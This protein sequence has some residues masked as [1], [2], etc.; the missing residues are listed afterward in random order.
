VSD[1]VLAVR[2]RALGDVVL[3]TPALRALAK[4]HPDAEVHAVTDPR[5]VPLLEGAPG[6]AHVWPLERSSAGSLRLIGAL[7][8]RRIRAAVDFFGNPR[9]A[10][11]AS[12]CGAAR[13]HGYALR[14]RARAYHVTVP[15]ERRPAPDRREYAAATHVRLAESVGGVADGLEARLAIGPAAR[16]DATRLLEAAGVREPGRTIA[17]VAAG[18]WPTKT[19]PL[20]H[21][22]VL[23]RRLAA[24]GHPLLLLSGPGEDAVV[25]RLAALAPGLAVL[26]PCG[27]AALV[28]VLARLGAVVGTDSGPR[29][30]AAAFGVPTFSWFGPTHPDTWNPP[31]DRHGFWRTA[32]PCRACDRTA[33]PHWNCLPGLDPRA[34]AR[35]VLNHLEHHGRDASDLGTPAR[36]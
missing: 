31:G 28:A 30:V 27:V 4:G 10:V 23:A 24:A 8:R 22:A 7:R 19:W 21:V 25:R 36:A 26:P 3:V 17:L 34:A 18:T 20:S 9:S 6:V 15:R 5:Y 12:R 32:L 13:V 29:H 11:V 2:L 16:D 1:V 33:C 14:G 35:L